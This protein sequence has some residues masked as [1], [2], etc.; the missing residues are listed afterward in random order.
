MLTSQLAGSGYRL[1]NPCFAFPHP[2][3]ATGCLFKPDKHNKPQ[4]GKE[5]WKTKTN[6]A[7]D[8]TFIQQQNFSR[9]LAAKQR[10]REAEE[11][12]GR[13]LQVNKGHK[14]HHSP[15]LRGNPSS[16]PLA[17][18]KYRLSSINSINTL[19]DP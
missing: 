8:V 4:H 13:V 12:Q 3:T 6:T 16:A 7:R 10:G 14:P 15:T 5:I 2:C 19:H 18:D 9:V 1:L 17:E 11:K